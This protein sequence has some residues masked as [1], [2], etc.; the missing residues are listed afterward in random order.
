[1][2][3]GDVDNLRSTIAAS[4]RVLGPS[5]TWDFRSRSGEGGR[6]GSE[7]RDHEERSRETH[8]EV[9]SADEGAANGVGGNKTSSQ[10]RS[11]SGSSE[12]A[13]HEDF[14]GGRIPYR[15]DTHASV[16]NGVVVAE[17]RRGSAGSSDPDHFIRGKLQQ[18]VHA[19][20][21][22]W[23]TILLTLEGNGNNKS[24]V[25]ARERVLKGWNRPVGSDESFPISLLI[26]RPR[27][28]KLSRQSGSADV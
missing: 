15:D 11:S 16:R 26:P 25:L 24:E 12:A 8:L 22:G 28:A 7:R 4:F 2:F 9:L 1:M 21:F 23:T 14:Q 3:A 17:E 19:A 13:N 6:N 5:Y 27:A 10:L 20:S 18:V